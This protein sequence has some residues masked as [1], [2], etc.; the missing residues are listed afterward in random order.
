LLFANLSERVRRDNPGQNESGVIM[1][2]KRGNRRKPSARG[3]SRAGGGSGLT[4]WYA[5]GLLA[6]G[7]IVAYDH[8][9]ELK[10]KLAATERVAVATITPP[11]SIAEK[12]A[13]AP[14][15]PSKLRAPSAPAALAMP[16]PPASIPSAPVPVIPVSAPKPA[17]LPA[18]SAASESFGFCGDGPHFNCV[19]DGDTFWV[20]GV[21]IR[22]ADIDTP[23]IDPPACPEA[24]SRGTAAKLRLLSL[25]NGGAFTLQPGTAET[26]RDGAKYRTIYR[27]GR[28]IGMQM[29]SE[30]LAQPS[31]ARKP[32]CT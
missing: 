28:S 32:W 23:Q 2:T 15:T 12:P 14:M 4:P 18:P 17:Q 22:I 3:K 26:D 31:G 8:W 24:K 27:Q 29:V 11:H 30:G 25:L 20:R 7:G 9:P 1:A 6:L 13:L 10:P 21:K 16:V 19:V 5:V